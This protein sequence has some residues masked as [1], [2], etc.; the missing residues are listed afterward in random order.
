MVEARLQHAHLAAVPPPP[1]A[2]RSHPYGRAPG[3]SVTMRVVRPPIAAAKRVAANPTSKTLGTARKSAA[4]TTRARSNP[5]PAR[6]RPAKTAMP[7]SGTAVPSA[8]K[9]LNRT[10][11]PGLPHRGGSLPAST[12]AVIGRIARSTIKYCTAQVMPAPS[13]VGRTSRW[14]R[15][16][17]NTQARRRFDGSGGDIQ[18]TRRRSARSLD[19]RGYRRTRLR[20]DS[21]GDTLPLAQPSARSG[22]KWTAEHPPP[23]KYQRRHG[24]NDHNWNAMPLQ[25]PGH[26]FLPTCTVGAR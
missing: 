9:A 13:T 20:S 2:R 4:A 10:P 16:A 14:D 18:M 12:S 26:S 8:Q 21:V 11:T 25:F 6:S 17:S 19:S 1:P 22:G 24:E 15:T 3:P 23:P 5:T 7:R